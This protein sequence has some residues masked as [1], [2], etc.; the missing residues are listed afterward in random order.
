MYINYAGLI[1]DIMKTKTDSKT[2]G[3][4][5]FS[6]Y[7]FILLV[8]F[9]FLLLFLVITSVSPLK[10]NISGEMYPALAQ[11]NVPSLHL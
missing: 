11:L 2:T 5:Y 8:S 9:S 1:N 6:I 3:F 4:S 10:T 7:R